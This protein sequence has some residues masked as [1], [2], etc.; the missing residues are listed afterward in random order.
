M[1]TGIHATAT[2]FTAAWNSGAPEAVASIYAERGGIVINRGRPWKGRA[3]VAAMA[4]GFF[5]DV[6][7]LN[8]VCDGRRVAGNDVV[9]SWA[10]AGHHAGTRNPL[11]ITGRK[12]W[13]LAED[14]KVSASR[15]WFDAEGYTRQVAV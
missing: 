7:D 2:A 13:D 10:F 4:A 14:G 3:G 6:P 8:L 1:T 15:G 11:R 12:E 9:Y 5:D